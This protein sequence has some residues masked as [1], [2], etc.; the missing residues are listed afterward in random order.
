MTELERRAFLL[1]AA[2]SAFAVLTSG[3]VLAASLQGKK[4]EQKPADKPKDP[5][6]GKELKPGL[7]DD[8]S[9]VLDPA[10]PPKFEK[11]LE[12]K[13]QEPNG[14]FLEFGKDTIIV[15]QSPDKKAWFA[16]SAICTHKGCGVVYK[17]DDRCFQC[18]C[19]GSKFA[20]S[21]KVSKGQAKTDLTSY[22]TAEVKSGTKT[23][24]KISPN[25]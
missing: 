20:E 6:G 14:H 22:T 2:G 17:P 1:Y 12:T 9:F 13:K 11:R 15:S 3:N 10:N 16:V 25:K 18:P 5:K 4:P 21:G 24:V 7:Q 23:F 19:H 8:G